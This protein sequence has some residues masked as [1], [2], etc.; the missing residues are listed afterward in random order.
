ML[1]RAATDDVTHDLGS[2]WLLRREIEFP[3]DPIQC[4]LACR[5]DARLVPSSTRLAGQQR[6]QVA[7]GVTTTP[8]KRVGLPLL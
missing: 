2:R 1:R 7:T 8:Q 6:R 3:D 5:R 4:G